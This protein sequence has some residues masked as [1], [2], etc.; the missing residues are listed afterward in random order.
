MSKDSL[1]TGVFTTSER[2]AQAIDA[3]TQGGVPRDYISIVAAEGTKV[4]AFGIQKQTKAG[5]G[6]AIGGGIGGAVGALVAGFTAVGA[7]ATSG[8]GLIAAGPIVAALAGAGAGAAA[9]GVLGGLVGLGIPEHQVKFFQ[10]ALNKG[11]VLVGVKSSGG[12]REFIESTLDRFGAERSVTSAAVGPGAAARVSGGGVSPEE[13][14]EGNP[15]RRLF[16]EQVQDMYYAEQQL[17]DAIPK[18]RDQASHQ[19]LARAFDGHLGQT[20]GHVQR[21]EGLFADLGVK[22]KAV[23]CPAINGI[24]SESKELMAMDTT[25]ALRDAA[26]VC[27][28]QKAEHYEIA[29]YGCLRAYAEALGLSAAAETLQQ[30]LSE[31]VEADR[32]LSELAERHLNP[33]AAAPMGASTTES[34]PAARVM[35]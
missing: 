3:L 11:S 31:E 6:A 29:T 22:A 8:I 5:Q 10:D 30:T 24:I 33:M 25:P 34:K 21:L 32:V 7:L 23:K 9:G 2:A 12:N 16:I 15:L 26:L 28:A 13:W 19:D 18:L 1:I 20:R 27:A 35:F 17:V 4:E 14:A